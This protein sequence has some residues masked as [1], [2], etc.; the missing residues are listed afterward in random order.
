MSCILPQGELVRRAAAY[1][2]EERRDNPQLSLSQVLDRAGM[3]FNLSP[4]ESEALQALFTSESANK[5]A[6]GNGT[7]DS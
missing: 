2:V 1:I 3:R 5:T 6:V 7:A 4:L